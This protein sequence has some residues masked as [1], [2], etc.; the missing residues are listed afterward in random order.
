[1]QQQG[2]IQPASATY[3]QALQLDPKNATAYNNMANLL[4]I[5]GQAS[6]AISVYR[7]AIRL[8]PKNASAYYNLGVTLY[9]QGE[10]NKA[11]GVLKRAHNEYRQ[12]GN[13][14]Q[15]EKIQQLMQQIV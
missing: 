15:A 12:Q 6:E 10:F 9:N 7:Q 8:N 14:E 4:A 5:Q 3:R 1:M 11:S 13:I 2:Q